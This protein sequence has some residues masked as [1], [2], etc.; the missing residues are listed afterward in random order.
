MLLLLKIKKLVKNHVSFDKFIQKYL[1]H[2]NFYESTIE[3]KDEKF[4]IIE[5]IPLRLFRFRPSKKARNL[6]KQL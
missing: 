2:Y 1:I 6:L 4:R 5:S 3:I